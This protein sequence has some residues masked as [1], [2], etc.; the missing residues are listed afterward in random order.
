MFYI[1]VYM[2]YAHAKAPQGRY[3]LPSTLFVLETREGVYFSRNISRTLIIPFRCFSPFS[4]YF[5]TE[6]FSTRA[7]INIGNCDIKKV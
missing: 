4:S 7:E 6:N 5:L 2:C 3:P 1:A